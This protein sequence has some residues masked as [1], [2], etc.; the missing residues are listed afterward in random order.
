MLRKHCA[1]LV[2]VLIAAAGLAAAASTR[3]VAPQNAPDAS[4]SSPAI[5]GPG[6]GMVIAVDPETG[7]L[8]MPAPG[9]VGPA[10][11]MAEVQA[12]A[13][14]LASELVTLHHP[15]GSST[16][17]HD[18]RL[19]DYAVIRIA[20]DGTRQFV[21]VHGDHAAKGALGPNQ[22]VSPASEER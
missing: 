12:Y 19:A 20:P 18:E 5:A 15:D 6:S 17:I 13:R 2:T 21:C 10:P 7:E 3:G 16:L 9:Q 22:P 11:S 1:A 8:G 14:R 4:I